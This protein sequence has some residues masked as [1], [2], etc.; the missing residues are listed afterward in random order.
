MELREF[1][2]I[3]VAYEFV[4]LMTSL[5]ARGKASLQSFLTH[6]VGFFWMFVEV[7]SGISVFTFPYDAKETTK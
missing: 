1:C 7:C 2:I 3:T 6:F 5:C 4:K